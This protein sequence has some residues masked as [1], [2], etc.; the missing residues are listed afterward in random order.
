M[1]MAK[2]LAPDRFDNF[3]LGIVETHISM[4][5]KV[6]TINPSDRLTLDIAPAPNRPATANDAPSN[7]K[8]NSPASPPEP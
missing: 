6:N 8:T 2:S 1:F 4:Y 3:R 7:S 5:S